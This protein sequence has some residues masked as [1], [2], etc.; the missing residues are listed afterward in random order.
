MTTPGFESLYAD[1]SFIERSSMWDDAEAHWK[2]EQIQSFTIKNRIQANRIIDY[3]CGTGSVLNSLSAMFPDSSLL[4]FDPCSRLA[5]YWKSY[6]KIQF[7]TGFDIKS[8]KCDDLVLL[9]DVIEHVR[10]PYELLEMISSRAGY[11]VLHLPLEHNLLTLLRPKTLLHAYHQVGHLHFFSPVSFEVMCKH[12]DINILSKQFTYPYLTLSRFRN[13]RQ[14][15]IDLA[16]HCLARTFS[17]SLSQSLLGGN[18]VLYLLRKRP[19]L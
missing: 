10:D 1:D 17:P 19:N 2:S 5:Q 4:G 9:I 14:R 6:D 16:R 15:L 13:T 11:I 8:I 7:T 12:L 3:G 18:T